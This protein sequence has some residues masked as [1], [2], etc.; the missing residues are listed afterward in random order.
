MVKFIFLRHGESEY[1]RI[2]KFTGHLNARLTDVGKLQAKIASEYILQ[3]YKIDVVYSSDLSRAV[4][5]ATPVANAL[6]LS[7]NTDKRLREFDLGK[8]TDLYINDVKARYKDEFQKYK[9]GGSAMGGESILDVQRRAYDCVL[10][11]AKDNQNK[12]ALIATH[13]GVIR[14]LL[15]KWFNYPTTDLYK[16][17]IVSNNSITIVNYD[18]ENFFIEK[19]S[20]DGYLDN[21]KTAQDKNLV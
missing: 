21:I 14:A 4:D 2:K 8:W 19:V 13:G 5:T 7:I 6:N 20:Y 11:I 17:P 15:M 12:T 10:Q 18:N 9:S 1:N 3:N 16:I